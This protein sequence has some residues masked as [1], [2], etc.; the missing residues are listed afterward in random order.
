MTGGRIIIK[1]VTS[2]QHC[3]LC[4]SLQ[5]ADYFCFAITLFAIFL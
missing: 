2:T 1:P 3:V 4:I 5:A